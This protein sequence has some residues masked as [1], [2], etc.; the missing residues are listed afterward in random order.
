M[1]FP[2]KLLWANIECED[3]HSEFYFGIF[4]YFEINLKYIF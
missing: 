4:K 1:F 3:A 2:A